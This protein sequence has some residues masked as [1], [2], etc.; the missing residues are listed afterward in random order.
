VKLYRCDA[1]GCDRETPY[2]VA[3]WFSLCIG[4]D[5]AGMPPAR[6]F[7]S[8]RHLQDFLAYNF[9]RYLGARP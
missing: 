4:L 8:L 6:W 2:M 9:D 1:T 7:C 3:P 5:H